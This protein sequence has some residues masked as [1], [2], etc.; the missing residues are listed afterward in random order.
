M[1]PS[2]ELWGGVECT[3]A[4]VGDT[5][6]DQTHRTGHHD[7]PDDLD[8]IAA[9][10]VR[11]LRYPAT[12]ERVAPRGLDC[13][14]WQWT[15]DRLARLRRLGVRPILGLLHH[16]SGPRG[17]SLLD[18]QLPTA[19]E[20]YA[21]TVAERYPW[22]DAYTPIN[23]PLTTARFSALYGHWYPHLRDT[24]AFVRALLHQIEGVVRAMRAIRRIN[25]AAQLVQTEDGGRVS[26]TPSLAYQADFENRRRWLTFDLLAG[27]VDRHHPLRAWL[28]HHRAPLTLLDWLVDHPTPADVIGLNYYLT[29]DR[30]LDDRVG[31]FPPHLHGTN[32]RD[33]YA[34]VEAVRM[35]VGIAGHEAMLLEAWERYRAPVAITEVH[36][37][38]TGPDQIRW[39]AEAW[40]AAHAARR[41]GADVRAITVWALMGSYDWDSLLTAQRGSYEPGAFDVRHTPPHATLVATAVRSLATGGG[42]PD[43]ANHPGW[44]RR[45]DRILPFADHAHCGADRDAAAPVNVAVGAPAQ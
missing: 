14:D 11:A 18:P 4:R 37:G 36:A 21:G 28:V 41:A 42:L 8:R 6:V 20:R 30:H 19:F 15:D 12:W 25:P 3:V 2:V 10:G 1:T 40:R 26:S 29:S 33:C 34:D 31:R 5:F 22:V 43:Y 23:E 17:T 44:W 16:G 39:L 7:R 13:A 45:D 32:G 38:C 35:P 24:P 9:V 27:R